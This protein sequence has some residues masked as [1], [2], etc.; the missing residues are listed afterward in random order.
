VLFFVLAAP[1]FAASFHWVD[2]DGFHAVDR[3]TKVPLEHRKDLP[4][5]KNQTSLPF[6]E[7]ENRDGAMY[8]WFI[9]GQSGIGYSFT[10]AADFPKS[11]LFK[12]V[13]EPQAADIAWWKG[14]IAL[15]GG[16]GDVLLTAQGE[17]S[18]KTL[19]KRRGKVTWYRYDG[20]PP[21]NISPTAERAPL[22]ALK[23]ADG[24]LLSLDGAATFPP[25]VK[26]D[27][28]RDLLRKDWEKAMAGLEALRKKYTDDPQVLRLLGVGF[29]MGYNLA[30]P[31]AWERAEAYLLR[32]EELAPDA[33]EAYLSLGVLYA[34]SQPDYAEQAER[35][36]RTALRLARKEQLPQI[37]WGLALALY[38]QG[39]VQ[40]AVETI[41]RLI[42][43]RPEDARA[44]ELRETFLAAPKEN[45]Q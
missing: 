11:P 18:L 30:V 3:I 26:D 8:V 17:K 45:R 37:W 16:K 36:F 34:D 6:T 40:E 4:M 28:E 29:R 1:A 25:R 42:A 19:E 14:F 27:V 41:D 15:N 13:G 7:E 24:A 35:Q 9:L 44:R 39:K 23:S 21:A 32:A 12:K 20:P 38:H 2:R 43:L 33:P 10:R 22:K 5:V 31:G